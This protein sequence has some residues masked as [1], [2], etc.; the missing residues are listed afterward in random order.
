[1]A[2]QHKHHCEG[3]TKATFC[4]KCILAAYELQLTLR[5]IL[6]AATELLKIATGILGKK[7][8]DVPPKQQTNKQQRTSCAE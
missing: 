8:N 3:K 7:G 1:M 2:A 6:N 4:Y 5:K